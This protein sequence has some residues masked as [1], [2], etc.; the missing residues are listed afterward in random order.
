[1]NTKTTIRNVFAVSR[2][3]FLLLV[4]E[5]WNSNFLYEPE[6]G[7]LHFSLVPIIDSPIVFVG[8]GIERSGLFG[9]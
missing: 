1:M 3:Y 5:L 4:P 8:Q 9:E 2:I 7:A 6:F